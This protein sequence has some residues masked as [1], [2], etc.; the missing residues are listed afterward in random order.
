MLKNTVIKLAFLNSVKCNQ[1]AEATS[2]KEKEF[3]KKY[4]I[5]NVTITMVYQILILIHT[6]L[7]SNIPEYIWAVVLNFK[8]TWHVVSAKPKLN[9]I[10]PRKLSYT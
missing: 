6:K 4:V 2:E 5:N 9:L 10:L 3:I 1:T 8:M 7:F